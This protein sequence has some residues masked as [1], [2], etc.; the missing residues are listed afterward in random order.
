MEDSGLIDPVLE[1]EVLQNELQL[2]WFQGDMEYI[3]ARNYWHYL[4]GEV[5]KHW[6][7][8]NRAGQQI[9]IQGQWGIVN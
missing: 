2:R 5:E 6:L 1:L 9:I 3:L 4:P 8:L 7:L